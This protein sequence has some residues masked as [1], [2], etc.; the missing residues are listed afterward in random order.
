MYIDKVIEVAAPEFAAATHEAT[1]AVGVD[2]DRGEEQ[3][4][5]GG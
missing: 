5:S 4:A 3:R 2:R 1:N